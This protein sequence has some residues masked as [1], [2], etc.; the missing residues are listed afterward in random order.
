MAKIGAIQAKAHDTILRPPGKGASPRRPGPDAP[1]SR[2]NREALA[3]CKNRLVFGGHPPD[4]MEALPTG[5][6]TVDLAMSQNLSAFLKRW[7]ITTVAVMLAAS[8]VPG[9]QWLT[10]GGLLMATLL[11]G[12]LNAFV[13]PIMLLLSLPLLI[14]SLGLFVLIINALLLYGVGHILRDFHVDTFGAAFWGSLIISIV[15]MMLNLLVKG[16]GPRVEVH[17][18]PPRPPPRDGGGP[19]IDV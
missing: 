10:F 9:I 8:I 3:A 16:D 17:R 15:S 6:M 12:L 13:R 14:L 19:V 4:A 11:L 7:L 2:R 1:A 5:P 18:G